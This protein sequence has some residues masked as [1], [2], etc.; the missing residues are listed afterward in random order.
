MRAPMM[1]GWPRSRLMTMRRTYWLA[2]VLGLVVALLVDAQD[3]RIFDRRQAESRLE[4]PVLGAI[5]AT[6]LPAG[7]Q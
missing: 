4:V 5:S 1:N 2:V 7:R 6:E 3:H